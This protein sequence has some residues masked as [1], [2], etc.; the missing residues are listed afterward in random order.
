M[1]FPDLTHILTDVLW[2][3]IGGAATR[4]YMPERLTQDFD[5]LVQHADAATVRHQ[6]QAAGCHYNGELT[7][8]GSSWTLPDGWSVDVL[9]CR[10]SWGA[11]A[12]TQ[13]QA[14]RD[15]QGLP[16]LPLPY[17]VLMK[18]Q[19]GRVQDLADIVRMLGQASA[20]QL[21]QVRR[22]FATWLPEDVADL[23]CL[24]TLG[25]LEGPSPPDVVD[26]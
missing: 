3:V 24:I 6:L 10:D 20:T 1:Q 5:I 8:G 12:L 23:D 19:A 15:A 16:V 17:L 11:Q 4:L 7:I 18:F 26:S 21:T 13:A 14:N 22:V 2:A 9:E 25:Q